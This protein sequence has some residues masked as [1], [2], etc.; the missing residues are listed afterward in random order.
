VTA[1]PACAKNRPAYSQRK[2]R[3]SRSGVTSTAIWPTRIPLRYVRYVGYRAASAGYRAI[4]RQ[5]A[6]KIAG[7]VPLV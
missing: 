6:A 5:V 7:L 3:L 1:V 4:G 2:S